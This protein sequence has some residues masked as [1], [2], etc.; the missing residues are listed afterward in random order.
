MSKKRDRYK[1]REDSERERTRKREGE[2]K[3]GE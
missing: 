3:Q 2:R 1:G